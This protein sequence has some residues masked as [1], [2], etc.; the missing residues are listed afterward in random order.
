MA[1]VGI[2]GE[3]LFKT[4]ARLLDSRRG[5]GHRLVLVFRIA[6]E[7]FFMEPAERVP[8]MIFP[9]PSDPVFLEHGEEQQGE[10][11]FVNFLFVVP[12]GSWIHAAGDAVTPLRL[13]SLDTS[14]ALPHPVSQI[15]Q[16]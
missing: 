16:A 3:Q 10:N 1:V 2:T 5:Q 7:A 11:R 4:L 12:H 13:P 14:L 15:Q 8:I 9:C 6:D